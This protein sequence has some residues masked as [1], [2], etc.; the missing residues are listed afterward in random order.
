MIVLSTFN[1]PHSIVIGVNGQSGI[2]PPYRVE[3]TNFA[4]LS[5]GAQPDLTKFG[6]GFNQTQPDLTWLNMI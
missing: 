2:D 6:G 1:P 3:S 5:I 4:G